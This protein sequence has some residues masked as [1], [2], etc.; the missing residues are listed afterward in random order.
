MLYIRPR[1]TYLTQAFHRFY[2]PIVRT[3]NQASK[4]TVP[5]IRQQAKT[6]DEGLETLESVVE[7]IPKEKVLKYLP[8]GNYKV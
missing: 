7:D 6:D 4:D 3:L 8:I 5:R 2:I 1:A